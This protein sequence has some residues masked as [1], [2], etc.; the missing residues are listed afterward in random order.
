MSRLLEGKVALVTGAGRGLGR[1]FAEHLA[2]LGCH[3]G[4]HGLRENGPSEYGEGTTLTH[5][6]A[7]I[8]TA[9]STETYRVLGDLTVEA[10]AA[11]VVQEVTSELGPIDILVHS[12]GGDIAAAGGKPNPNDA[13]MIKAIDVRSVLDRNLMSTIHICQQVARGMMER[14]QGRI[15]TISSI[16]AFRGNANSAIYST[17]K[18]AVVEY[19][20]CLAE[21]LRPYEVTCNS[22]APGDTRTGRYLGTRTVDQSRLV[23]AGTLDRIGLVEEVAQVVEFFAGP[24][25]QFVTGQ[26]LRVDGGSQIWPA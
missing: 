2:K 10:D 24:L 26:A 14:R 9:Y 4:I 3:V 1:A 12:A 17:A 18:A 25:G 16:A 11:R 8:A 21:Q 13:V 19:T 22:L 20:R 23:E 6:A 5:T 15:I 7:E